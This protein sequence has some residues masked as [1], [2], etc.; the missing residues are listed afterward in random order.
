METDFWHEDKQTETCHYGYSFPLT[1][2]TQ[3]NAMTREDGF[4]G[5]FRGR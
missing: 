4:A 5:F 2:T 1:S 3:G